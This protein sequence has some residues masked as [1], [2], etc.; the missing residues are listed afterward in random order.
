MNG[1]VCNAS[2]LI[3]MA[4]ADLLRLIPE[5]FTDVFI[6]QAVV[7]EIKAGP[8]EDPMNKILACCSWLQPVILE[9]PLSPLS[10]W[11]LGR[12]EAEV[13]EYARMHPKVE[14]LLDDR[15]ARRAAVKLGIKVHGTLSVIAMATIQGRVP[16]FLEAVKQLRAAGL[17]AS[18]AV[19]KEVARKLAGT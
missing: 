6:P 9:P 19:V 2:P 3:T 4:K 10:V 18:D 17:Y 8:P 5:L 13:I 11:Q 16:S 7:D 15:L 1:V 12:G 14:A